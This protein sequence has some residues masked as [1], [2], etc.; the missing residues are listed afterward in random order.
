M[1]I[2]SRADIETWIIELLS[3]LTTIPSR[4]SVH[5]RGVD[6]G[7]DQLIDAAQLGPRGTDD[8]RSV[9]IAPHRLGPE[10][11]RH[12]APDQLLDAR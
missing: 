2:T 8:E 9:L 10:P 1:S 6:P 5:A 3:S 11:E 4:V 7:R 12:A